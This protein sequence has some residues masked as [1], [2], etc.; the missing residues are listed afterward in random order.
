MNIEQN[1]DM[2][3]LTHE[4][5]SNTNGGTVI[6]SSSKQELFHVLPETPIPP[7]GNGIEI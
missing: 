6:F 4:E 3:E 1:S 7:D 2:R 5:C